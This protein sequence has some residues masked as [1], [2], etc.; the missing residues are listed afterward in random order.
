VRNGFFK[1]HGLGNDYLALDPDELDFRLTPAAVRRLCDRTTGVGA[2][3]VAVLSPTRRADFGCRIFNPDG[4]EAERSGNGLRVFA[5]W[6]YATRRTRARC[7][8]ID[9]KGGVVATE[10]HLDAHGEAARATQALGRAR[11]APAALPCTLAGPEL[12]DRPIAAAG[13]RLRFTGVSVGNPHCVVFAEGRRGWR[14]DD[15][16]ALGPAL[17]RHRAFPRRVNLQLARVTGPRALDILVWERGAG[18]T[19]ASGTSACAAA[20]A[21]VRRGLVASPVRVRAPGGT[22]TVRVDADFDLHLEGP[23]EEIARGRLAEA[24]VRRLS[25]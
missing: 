9:T 10:L 11:F 17:E 20:A 21:A 8:R 18:E 14:R 15:L 4:S 16:L 23:V 13:R 5:R 1:A 2:D 24:F 7:F 22:L 3:G 12:V 25:R 6:L 19:A